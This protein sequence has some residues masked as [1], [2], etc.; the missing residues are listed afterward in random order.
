MLWEIFR[1]TF[2]VGPSKTRFGESLSFRGPSTLERTVSHAAEPAKD[3]GYPDLV[4]LLD[5][6]Q[7]RPRYSFTY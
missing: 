7:R 6:W 3:Q 1:A 2:H 4:L 5:I